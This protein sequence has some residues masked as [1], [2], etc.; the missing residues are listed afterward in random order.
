MYLTTRPYWEREHPDATLA[1]GLR[2]RWD[3]GTMLEVK[4]G[5]GDLVRTTKVRVDHFRGYLASLYEAQLM[6][7]D[8]ATTDYLAHIAMK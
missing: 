1:A 4:D 8:D 5:Q 7:E 3:T 6:R 2:S